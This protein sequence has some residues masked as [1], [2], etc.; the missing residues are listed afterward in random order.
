MPLM[1]NMFR[2]RAPGEAPLLH[3][4]FQLPIEQAGF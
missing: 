3:I 2:M 1:M 4:V